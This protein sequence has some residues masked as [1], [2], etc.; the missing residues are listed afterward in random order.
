MA[1]STTNG[2]ILLFVLAVFLGVYVYRI[3]SE[4]KMLVNAYPDYAEYRK[5]TWRLI[6]LVY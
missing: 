2:I 4:E 3:Q 5:H 6:P 1:A